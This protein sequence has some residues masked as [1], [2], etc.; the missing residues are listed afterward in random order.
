[1][2]SF[3]SVHWGFCHRSLRSARWATAAAKVSTCRWRY[4]NKTEFSSVHL[5]S[6]LPATQT[7]YTLHYCVF[8]VY[9]CDNRDCTTVSLLHQQTPIELLALLDTVHI[10]AIMWHRAENTA[11]HKT[12]RYDT[13]IEGIIKNNSFFIEIFRSRQKYRRQIK[14]E[15]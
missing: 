10:R 8:L 3:A 12:K 4:I 7:S 2:A 9:K 14:I 1:M 5:N 15:C 13:G 11:T 6:M